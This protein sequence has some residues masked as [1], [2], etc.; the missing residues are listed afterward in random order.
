MSFASCKRIAPLDHYYGTMAG[1]RGFSDENAMKLEG[2]RS[3]FHQPDP[4]HPDGHLLPFHLD[5]LKTSAQKIPSTRATHGRCAARSMER[6]KN[7]Q[8]AACSP[9]GGRQ[10]GAIR[11]G[12]LH[13]RRHSF[14]FRAGRGVHDLRCLP[15]LGD[16][17]DL[18]EP[19]VLD[20]G[21]D[22]CRR[23]VWRT[24]DKQ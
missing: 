5:T 11:D 13:P 10:Q 9:S 8:L 20:D 7:G 12:L 3:I 16:G 2:G 14:P 21:H 4:K 23:C 22:R 24:R 1:V 15:L 17:P 18:A 19:H 6:R